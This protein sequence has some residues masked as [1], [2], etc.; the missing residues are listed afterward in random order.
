MAIYKY[1]A[2]NIS[3]EEISGI[4]TVGS[5]EELK[6]TL[7]N[8][9]YF[10]VSATEEGKSINISIGKKIKLR[11]FTLFCRQ[12]AVILTSGLTVLD[13]LNLIVQQTTNK[14]FKQVLS[15]VY[16][17][18][19]K[20][21]QLATSFSEHPEVF[22]E[23]FVD[24]IQVGEAT[25]RLDSVLMELA[26]YYE[27]EFK[28]TSKV[29]KAVTYPVIVVLVAVLVITLLM[30]VVLPSF[31]KI[32]VD[33][34]ATLP[35]LTVGVMAISTFMQKNVLIIIVVAI[36]IIFGIRYYV[37]TEGGRVKFDNLKLK[38]PIFGSFFLKVVTARFSRSMS[39]LLSSG[40]PITRAMEIITEV[41]GN[42]IVEEKFRKCSSEIQEGKSIATSIEK[43]AVFPPM[44]NQM[45]YVGENTG[46][47]DSMLGKT[48]DFFDDDVEIALE[49]MI[50]L[51]EP[52][53]IISLA[54]IVGTIILAVMLPMLSIMESI[55]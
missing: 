44:L 40:I 19:L 24:M 16:E 54:V 6:G 9:G 52:A 38:A 10:L 4:E 22:P 27:R 50:A 41:M 2:K 1:V 26:E 13:G 8:K 47:M 18:I 14:Y 31:N 21:N 29:K 39:I 43:M 20:G 7:G 25:G 12:Y 3:G 36:A 32:L 35:P 55:A 30:V 53:L 33:M 28:M 51:I 34:G 17:K 46:E 42:K 23:F 45:I 15:E 11:D 5:L 48:A 49:Q 37:N